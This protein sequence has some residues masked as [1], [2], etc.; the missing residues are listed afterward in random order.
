VPYYRRTTPRAEVD[1][2][3]YAFWS[4]D[5]PG[6]LSR[7]RNLDMGGVFI[8]TSFRKDVGASVELYFL[9]SEGQ[10]RAD[11]VVR[12]V[13]PGHG[14][15]LKFTTLDDRDRLRFGALMKRLYSARCAGVAV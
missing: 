11:G 2:G 12:H 8:E 9:V 3:V 14:L 7:V 5:G 4:C 10:I 13:E 6:D 1:E 15:G